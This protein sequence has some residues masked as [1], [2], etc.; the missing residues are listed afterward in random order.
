MHKNTTIADFPAYHSYPD[1]GKRHPGL[2]VIH[3]IW[4]LDAHI[5]N[6]TDRFAAQNYSVVAPNL[7]HGVSFEGKID[8]T[9]LAEMHNPDT[10][11]EA[12]KKMRALMAPIMAPE[13]TEGA[14]AKLEQ[15]VD[16]LANDERVNGELAVLG[17][18]FGG[19][20]SFHLAA[21]DARVKA[22]VPFYGHPPTQNEIPNINCP[23]LA[24]YGDQDANLMQ[25][26]PQLKQDMGKLHKNFEAVVYQN[27]GH[28]FFNDTNVRMYNAGAASAAWKK[29]LA[30]LQENLLS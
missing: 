8:S 1:D 26:L 13:F 17:F 9:L 29:T 25:S 12:Q 14:V 2:I 4:G 21:H 28:A 16:Y 19:T 18:C 20:Y 10:R 5:K 3:E 30:F 7:F 22:A 27:A 24:F 23:V 15:C 11:D 6:V